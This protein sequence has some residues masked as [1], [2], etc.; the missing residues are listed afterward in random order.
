MNPHARFTKKLIE[1]FK[2]RRKRKEQA[3]VPMHVGSARMQKPA[4]AARMAYTSYILR[5]PSR[6]VICICKQPETDNKISFGLAA[7]KMR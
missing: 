4:K 5:D 2:K 7:N 6:T 3:Q 1:Q